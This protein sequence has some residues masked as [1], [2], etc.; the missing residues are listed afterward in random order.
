MH[1][2][3]LK[4][5]ITGYLSPTI[6]L[7]LSTHLLPQIASPLTS[8]HMW[9]GHHHHYS[10]GHFLEPLTTPAQVRQENLAEI[11]MPLNMHNHTSYSHFHTQCEEKQIR[12]INLHQCNSNNELLHSPHRSRMNPTQNFL[13]MSRLMITYKTKRISRKHGKGTATSPNLIILQCP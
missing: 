3:I 5:N 12:A 9:W 7:G 2:F 11:H 4:Y 13:V 10:W 1:A 8:S 6:Q